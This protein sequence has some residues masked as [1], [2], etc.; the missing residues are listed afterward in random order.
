MRLSDEKIKSIK[1]IMK[2]QFNKDLTD[3]EAHLVGLATLEFV[4]AK[5]RYK[6]IILNISEEEANG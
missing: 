5:A 6:P 3:E 1:L 4:I 2:N